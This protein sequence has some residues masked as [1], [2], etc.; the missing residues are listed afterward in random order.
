MNWPWSAK[1]EPIRKVGTLA[2]LTDRATDAQARG[3][4]A[5]K[6]GASARP[7]KSFARGVAVGIAIMIPIWVWL[8][9]TLL[10]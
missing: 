1:P 10:R 6:E 2:S 5:E 3:L 9:L 7:G 4:D 8:V